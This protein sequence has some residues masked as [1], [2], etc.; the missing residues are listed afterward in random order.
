M[1]PEY[2][3]SGW[4]P[5]DPRFHEIAASAQKYVVKYQEL[6]KECR[7]HIVPGTIVIR[8]PSDS[9]DAESVLLNKTFFIEN[10]GKILGE[11]TKV[12]LWHPERDHLT[13]GPDYCRARGKEEDGASCSTQESSHHEVIQTPIG[14]VGLLICYDLCFPEASRALVKAGA[15]IIII[16]TFTKM[17][18]MSPTA[19]SYNE[20]GE[21]L[22]VQSA[23]VSRAFENTCCVLFCNIGGPAEDG[24]MGLSQ[25]V[26]PIVG[27]VPGGFEDCAE[28]MKVVDVDLNLIDVAEDNYKVRKDLGKEGFHYR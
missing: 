21:K 16:P 3:L 15:R 26:L 5:E 11:Y 10:T 22:F 20:H 13:S 27:P 12:N 4:Q 8:A 28:G 23:L 1:L 18:D 19:R 2:H 9:G 14:P 7:I 25:A 17:D 24:Y 6:A